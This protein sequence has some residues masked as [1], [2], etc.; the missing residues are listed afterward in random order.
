MRRAMRWFLA[1]LATFVIVR[2]TVVCASVTEQPAV[3]PLCPAPTSFSVRSWGPRAL[4]PSECWTKR[5][6]RADHRI[7]RTLEVGVAA[8]LSRRANPVRSWHRCT[9]LLPPR[10]QP[11]SGAV[12]AIA[13]GK[14]GAE[15]ALGE[16]GDASP[17]GTGDRAESAMPMLTHD[18]WH[19]TFNGRRTS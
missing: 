19:L 8:K 16:I 2:P 15:I 11:R 18:G 4:E 7:R 13:F 9:E 5:V 1:F 17:D 10:Q 3:G 6:G 12:V 14:S